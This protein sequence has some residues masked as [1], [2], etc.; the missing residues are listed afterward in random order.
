MP[1]LSVHMT[2]YLKTFALRPPPCGQALTTLI[3]IY[4][5]VLELFRT[6]IYCALQG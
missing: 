4:G 3:I 1:C 5:R 6:H 2:V